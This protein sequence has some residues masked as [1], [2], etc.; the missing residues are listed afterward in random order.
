MAHQP[1]TS[2]VIQSHST[3]FMHQAMN[4]A[5]TVMHGISIANGIREAAPIVLGGMRY[6]AG[7]IPMF[8]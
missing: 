4:A 1:M 7:M 3:P 8:L 6:A 2:K 5:S